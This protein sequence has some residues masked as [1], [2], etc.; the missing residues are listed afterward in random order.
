V[1]L[2]SGAVATIL[3]NAAYDAHSNYQLGVCCILPLLLWN[4]VAMVLLG[5]YPFNAETDAP[6]AAA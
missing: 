3:L 1:M 5:R 4:A 6:L 2:G